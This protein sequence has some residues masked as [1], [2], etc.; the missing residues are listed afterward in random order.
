[1]RVR[2]RPPLPHPQLRPRACQ[3]AGG[4]GAGGRRT[5]PLPPPPPC[6]RAPASRPTQAARAAAAYAPPPGR[7]SESPRSC[8][9]AAAIKLELAV[10]AMLAARAVK[11]EHMLELW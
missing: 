3:R 4:G 7:A 11:F 6:A 5:P 8:A 1:M 10:L 9:R 2:H